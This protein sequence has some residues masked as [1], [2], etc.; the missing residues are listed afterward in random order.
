[1]GACFS[2][3]DK[4]VDKVQAL[5]KGAG[6]QWTQGLET[7]G[8][9]AAKAARR[10]KL[11]KYALVGCEFDAETAEKAKRLNVIREL[12]F[13]QQALWKAWSS[14]TL[15]MD[16]SV[17][18]H[19]SKHCHANAECS[20]RLRQVALKVHNASVAHS[21]YVEFMRGKF[22]EVL[23]QAIDCIEESWC[24]Y[25]AYEKA[26]YD[27]KWALKTR[28]KSQETNKEI[29]AELDKAK[30]TALKEA[31]KAIDTCEA[32]VEHTILVPLYQLANNALDDFTKKC[33]KKREVKEEHE[34]KALVA[35][36][37]RANS[38]AYAKLKKRTYTA[39]DTITAAKKAF[40]GPSDLPENF[41]AINEN[42]DEM[43]R[44]GIALSI[45]FADFTPYIKI[46]FGPDRMNDFSDEMCKKIDGYKAL[47]RAAA[48]FNDRVAALTSDIDIEEFEKLCTEFDQVIRM[49]CSQV[50]ADA[51]AYLKSLQDITKA[52]KNLE[53]AEKTFKNQSKNFVLPPVDPKKLEKFNAQKEAW[54]GA[55]RDA[56]DAVSIAQERSLSELQNHEDRYE[57]LCLKKDSTFHSFIIVAVE[58]A[59][60][61]ITEAH[62]TIHSIKP[63]AIQHDAEAPEEEE[64]V[65][66]PKLDFEEAEESWRQA[67]MAKEEAEATLKAKEEADRKAKQAEGVAEQARLAAMAEADEQKKQEKLAKVAEEEAKAKAEAEAKAVA[68]AKALEAAKMEAEKAKKAEA[69]AQKVAKQLEVEV[70]AA[71]KK[72][73]AEIAEVET[74]EKAQA[75]VRQE[76][77]KSIQEKNASIL[78][79]S[80]QQTQSLREQ[81]K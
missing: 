67:E 52:E 15:A 14:A 12:L 39:G 61:V 70:A 31:K 57:S 28:R 21:D 4:A 46:I 80:M 18:M 79:K 55:L 47:K 19:W 5:A 27:Y 74:K 37:E 44:H 49:E 54:N 77:I 81:A 58:N 65:E 33:S 16:F 24:V 71:E 26:E 36:F 6:A 45:V 3:P 8:R 72:A 30:S 9:A 64:V 42:V 22:V 23:D 62:K 40:V 76:T 78:E 59:C 11:T 7:S 17:L 53:S 60:A 75:M 48:Q 10:A 38:I 2:L 1:M 20:K 13:D 63:R 69:V 56:Q 41:L 32:D 73:D 34:E 51:D 25:E 50:S 43:K 35:T 29:I 68:E 66:A